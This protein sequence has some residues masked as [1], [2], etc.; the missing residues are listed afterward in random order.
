MDHRT[1]TN[2]IIYHQKK[3]SMKREQCLMDHRT[4]TLRH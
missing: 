4:E 2:S 1:E 3:E